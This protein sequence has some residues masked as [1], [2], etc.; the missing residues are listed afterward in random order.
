MDGRVGR[1]MGGWLGG[2]QEEREAG[3]G[4]RREGEW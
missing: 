1:L 3:M 4:G 2:W